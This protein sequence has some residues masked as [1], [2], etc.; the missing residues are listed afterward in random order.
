MSTVP[1]L[2]GVLIN[3]AVVPLAAVSA[4][5][6]GAGGAA[7]SC[8]ERF[9]T[10]DAKI[11]DPAKIAGFEIAKADSTGSFLQDIAI[12]AATAD[13]GPSLQGQ[14][15]GK[16]KIVWTFDGATDL[17]AACIYEGGIS[18]VRPLGRPKSCTADIQRTRDTKDASNWG[19]EK[20]SLRCR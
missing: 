19:M 2:L 18:L 3:L 16:K 14:A 7:I 6:Q 4:H 17:V 15:D 20:A 10:T 8:P 5:A 13:A 1:R 9:K 12:R 11:A